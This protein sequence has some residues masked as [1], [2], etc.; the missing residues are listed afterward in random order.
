MLYQ[1][2]ADILLFCKQL[3]DRAVQILLLF[4]K[5]HASTIRQFF[6]LSMDCLAEPPE[7]RRCS[8]GEEWLRRILASDLNLQGDRLDTACTWC[9]KE[10]IED[11]SQIWQAGM[12]SEFVDALSLNLDDARVLRMRIVYCHFPQSSS[13]TRCHQCA[14]WEGARLCDEC[15]HYLRHHA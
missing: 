10:G 13:R 5:E 14:L 11:L 9:D 6:F 4:C 8:T 1:L 2:S 12:E 3:L 15:R 7:S